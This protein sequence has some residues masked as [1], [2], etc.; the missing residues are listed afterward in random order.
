MVF[1]WNLSDSKFPQIYMTFLSVLA[2][3]NHAV[4]WMVSTRP[5]ISESSSAFINPSATLS[6]IACFSSQD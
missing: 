1:H 4:V 5:I 3:F 6:L 2:G